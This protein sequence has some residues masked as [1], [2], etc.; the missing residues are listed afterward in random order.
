MKPSRM[1]TGISMAALLPLAAACGDS[2]STGLTAPAGPDGAGTDAGAGS[3]TLSVAVATPTGGSALVRSPALFDVVLDDGA[4][5]LVI[6]RVA[7]VLREIELERQF[8]D[9][10]DDHVSGSD[11]DC[12]EFSTGP[13]ILELPLDGSVDQV[14]AIGGVPADTYDE[15]E[16][17]IHRPEDDTAEDLAFLQANPDFRRVSI[18]AEGTFDGEPFVYTTDLDEEQEH[19]LVPPLVVTDASAPTNVTFSVDVS[20]WFLGTGGSLIDPRTANEG[21]PNEDLVEAN[22]ERSIDLFED[23]DRDGDDDGSDDGSDDGIASGSDD[24][25]ADDNGGASGSDDSGNIG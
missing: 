24:T 4:A 21:G 10:C 13:M 23:H 20:G 12:E 8:D 6:T 3:V 25:G 16:F 2:S 22:I 18:R 9:D 14:L 11:D 19:A 1:M 7:M 15:V 5:E 17:E